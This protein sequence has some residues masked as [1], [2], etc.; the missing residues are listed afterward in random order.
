MFIFCRENIFT[1]D[2]EEKET[3]GSLLNHLTDHQI[4]FAYIE[5]LSYIEKGPK[6]ITIE[7][8]CTRGD[9]RSFFL[10]LQNVFVCTKRNFL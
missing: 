9:A 2:T 6:F 10:Y 1:K 5:K 8:R 3:A 4:I 7:T